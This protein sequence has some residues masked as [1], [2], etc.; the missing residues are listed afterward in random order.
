MHPPVRILHFYYEGKSTGNSGEK[1][2]MVDVSY[3][4]LDGENG[5]KLDTSNYSDSRAYPKTS[6]THLCAENTGCTNA[7]NSNSAKFPDNADGIERV[8][9][10]KLTYRFK[11]ASIL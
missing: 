8:F 9:L 2:P 11:I 10:N 6:G 1:I 4:A 7:G 5:I 3:V